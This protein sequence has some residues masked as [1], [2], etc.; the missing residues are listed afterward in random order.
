MKVE[1]LSLHSFRGIKRLELDF[2]E[3]VT[4]FVGVNGVGKSAALD[5]LAIALSQAGV[6]RKGQ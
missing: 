3:R 6:K 1:R 4:A 5:A 2:T